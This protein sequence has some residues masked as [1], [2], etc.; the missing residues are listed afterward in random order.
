V[1]KRVFDVLVGGF[2]ALLALPVIIVCAAIVAVQL[3][4][5]PF[6]VQRRIGRRG[7]PFHIIKLRTL[8]PGTAPYAD[9][10]AL[11][12]VSTP[13]FAAALRRLHLDELPQLFLV[14]AGTMSLVGPRP[15]MPDLHARLESGFAR[16]RTALRPGCTG[17]WQLSPDR[18]GLIGEAPRW[19]DW[20]AEHHSLRTDVWILSRTVAVLAGR[21]RPLELS[22]AP[23]P[24]SRTRSEAD[25]ELALG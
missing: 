8:R 16:R 17:P 10:Y 13:R 22:D 14:V 20:Y 19:D 6:F 3:R 18:D 15:E 21:G 23:E 24:R 12:R 9:K 25:G 1:A 5:Q 4:A 2:L 11:G 7:R